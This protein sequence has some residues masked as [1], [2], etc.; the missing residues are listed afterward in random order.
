MSS[1]FFLSAAGSLSGQ[2]DSS[3]WQKMTFWRMARETPSCAGTSSSRLAHLVESVCRFWK[4]ERASA[5][6]RQQVVRD[7]GET[8]LTFLST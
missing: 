4:Q 2:L 1:N 6:G 7:G 5:R 8:L 3:W